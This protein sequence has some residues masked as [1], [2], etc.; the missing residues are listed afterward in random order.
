M[1]HHHHHHHDHSHRSPGGML[2]AFLLN[3]GFSILE[4]IGGLLTG[5]VAILS[6]ALH[7]LGD[8]AGIGL[9]CLLEKKSRKSPDA[10]HTYGYLRYSAL[11]G[12]I[13]TSFLLAGSCLVIIG[14]VRRLLHPTALHYDGMLL[15]AVVGWRSRLSSSLSP[16]SKPIPMWSFKVL[17]S[18]AFS[19]AVLII[20]FIIASWSTLSSTVGDSWQYFLP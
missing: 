13:T 7:D 14:A 8:A 2:V 11:G 1:A 17:S 15:F 9:S 4:L 3:L 5:S 10:T 6:D 12:F 18:S 16:I 19:F 20:A